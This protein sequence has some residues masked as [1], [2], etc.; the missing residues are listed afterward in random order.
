LP[1][2]QEWEKA[3]RGEDGR[4]YPWGDQFDESACN[5]TTSPIKGIWKLWGVSVYTTPVTQYPNGMSPYGCY[6]M[7]GNVTEWCA[8]WYNE[9]ADLRVRRGSSYCD[10]LPYHRASYRPWAGNAAKNRFTNFGFR[11]AQ[12]IS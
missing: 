4:Q 9:E 1:T 11:L 7:V 8:D 2:E 12:D 6:D 5:C 10:P 3:A